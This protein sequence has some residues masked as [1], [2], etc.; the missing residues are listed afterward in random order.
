MGM[1]GI[2]AQSGRQQLTVRGSRGIIQPPADEGHHGGVVQGHAAIN[3]NTRG[4]AMFIIVSYL[5]LAILFLL[6]A[7]G[8]FRPKTWRELPEKKVKLIQFGCYFIFV[9]IILNLL[10]RFFDW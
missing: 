4:I 2:S 1:V 5:I 6:L 9:V 8:I 3:C 10:A 7:T